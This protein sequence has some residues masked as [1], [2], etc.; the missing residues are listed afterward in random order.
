MTYA[1]MGI[2][3]KAQGKYDLSLENY[4]KALAIRIEKLGKDHHLTKA[5]QKQVDELKSKVKWDGKIFLIKMNIFWNYW[6]VYKVY[7][8]DILIFCMKMRLI[9]VKYYSEIFKG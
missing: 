6:Y 5:M 9:L 2:V 1:N 8:F 4:K 7:S 3:Y